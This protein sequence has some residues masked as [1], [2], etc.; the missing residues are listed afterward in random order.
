MLSI[1][2]QV[3][4]KRYNREPVK[5]FKITSNYLLSNTQ[6]LANLCLDEWSHTCKVR[7]PAFGPPP[8]CCCC[9]LLL[10]LGAFPLPLTLFAISGAA[11]WVLLLL[12]EAVGTPVLKRG[13]SFCLRR[14]LDARLPPPTN[15]P[16]LFSFAIVHLSSL[17]GRDHLS[18]HT[19]N[20]RGKLI[21]LDYGKSTCVDCKH[22]WQRFTFAKWRWF[23]LRLPDGG[24]CCKHF[25]LTGCKL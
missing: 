20:K 8:R 24:C 18:P 1:I 21:Y 15:G 13:F 11:N 25:Y 5:Y 14:F 9:W 6:Y 7:L 3:F 19:R 22:F 17:L 16:P 12:G 4:T 10:R 23:T 2:R